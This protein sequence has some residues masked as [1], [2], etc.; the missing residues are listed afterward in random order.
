MTTMSKTGIALTLALHGLILMLAWPS[1]R[2]H[3]KAEMALLTTRLIPASAKA[4][5]APHW[6]TP[7]PMLR[8]PAAPAPLAPP[9]FQIAASAEPAAARAAT[10]PVQPQPVLVRAAAPAQS[11]TEPPPPPATSYQPAALPPE[12]GSC[13]ARGVERHYPSLLRERGVEGQVLLRVQVDEQGR[14][15]EV[16]VQGGSG[17]RLLDEAARRIALACPYLAARRGDERLVA[18]VEYPVRFALH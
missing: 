8:T 18:W 7:R 4:A 5:A 14:A 11:Q 3:H 17:W 12:H 13:S 6:P 15:T 9:E 1:S 2:S 10:P 16:V